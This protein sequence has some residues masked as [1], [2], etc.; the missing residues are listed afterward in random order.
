MLGLTALDAGD[1]A[2]AVTDLR[3]AVDAADQDPDPTARIAARVGLALAIAAG[4]EVDEALD[5]GESAAALARQIGD[6]HLEAAVEDH[7]ADLLHA[8]GRD[9]EARPHQRARGRRLRRGR[10]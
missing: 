8:A 7:L 3:R 5:V 2:S 9:D 10:R 1:L 6:R 4:G